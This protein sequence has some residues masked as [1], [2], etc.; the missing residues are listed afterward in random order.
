MAAVV[1]EYV[2]KALNQNVEIYPEIYSQCSVKADPIYQDWRYNIICDTISEFKKRDI[3]IEDINEWIVEMN[4]IYPWNGT[5]D[6]FRQI[7]NRRFV[8]FPWIVAMTRSSDEVKKAFEVSKNYNIP[9]C[10]RSGSHCYENFSL[11]SNGMIIDQSQRTKIIVNQNNNQVTI[12][13]GVLNGPLAD[14]LSKYGLAISQGTC[15]N[16]GVTGLSLG[17]GIGFLSRKYGL[18]CDNIVSFKILVADGRE[19]FVDTNTYPDLFWACKGAG[20]ANFGIV[21][22]MTIQA[23]KVST[24][25]VFELFWPVNKLWKVLKTYFKWAK[26]NKSSVGIEMNIFSLTRQ[27]PVCITGMYTGTMDRLIQHIKIFLDLN[28]C[29]EKIWEDSYLASVR[30]FT[31]LKFPPP[32]FKNKSCFIYNELPKKIVK[33]IKKYMINAGPNDRIEIDCL[34]GQV[35]NHCFSF[36]HRD[37]IMWMQFITRWGLVPDNVPQS[38]LSG[39]N[40]DGPLRIDWVTKFYNE[41][42][43]SSNGAIRGAYVGC[44]DSDLKNYLEEYYGENL[45]KLKK[46]K[47]RYDPNGVFKYPQSL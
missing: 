11:I 6:I 21:T 36:A 37:A 42:K 4:A 46:I 34:M 35:R 23:H 12:Q 24:V 43:A 7:M 22:E 33:V 13:S 30:H 14:E 18:A 47:K 20:N 2:T 3:K 45:H 32:Y 9:L 15:A 39:W 5:Y 10:I 27:F 44:F 8:A 17:G 25:T 16:V 40:D 29:Q 1:P 38:E 26:T 41:M 19:L 31:Y 28:P